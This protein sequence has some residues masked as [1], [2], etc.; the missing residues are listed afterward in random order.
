M[1]M[2]GGDDTRDRQMSC[3]D[4]C[5]DLKKIMVSNVG[6]GIKNVHDTVM[7]EWENE[8]L[9]LAVLSIAIMLVFNTMISLNKFN[10][11]HLIKEGEK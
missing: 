5:V 7:G 4:K 2:D 10:T 3:W 6:K 9:L 11:E 8:S 1:Q